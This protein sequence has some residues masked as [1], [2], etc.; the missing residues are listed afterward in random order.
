[1]GDYAERI[2]YKTLEGGT[3]WKTRRSEYEACYSAAEPVTA[4]HPRGSNATVSTAN[5]RP[6]E[7]RRNEIQPT[8]SSGVDPFGQVSP[9]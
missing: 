2:R 4:A 8:G 3:L 7:E 5:F 9:E 1:V 6:A